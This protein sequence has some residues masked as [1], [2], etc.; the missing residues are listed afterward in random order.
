M[1]FRLEWFLILFF[2]CSNADP[3]GIREV[4]T[5]LE[6]MLLLFIHTK[7]GAR[8]GAY[9]FL[10]GDVKERA[11]MLKAMRDHINTIAFTPNAFLVAITALAC[12]DDTTILSKNLLQ[13]LIPLLSEVATSTTASRIIYSVLEEPSTS[14]FTQ[15]DLKFIQHV[16]KVPTKRSKLKEGEE[17]K[18]N[19][20]GLVAA[21]LKNA[22]LRRSQL[23]DFLMEPLVDDCVANIIKYLNSLSGAGIIKLLIQA[24]KKEVLN[25]LY[26]SIDATSTAP[27]DVKMTDKEDEESEKED[28]E[29]ED[30]EDED[31]DEEG[32]DVKGEDEDGEDEEEEEEEGSKP[33]KRA[34]IAPSEEENDKENQPYFTNKSASILLSNLIKEKD[35]TLVA[36]LCK[37]FAGNFGY[38]AKENSNASFIINTLLHS[39]DKKACAQVSFYNCLIFVHLLM[40]II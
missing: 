21:S 8:I 32:E 1:F 17:V 25:A 37:A 27:S 39:G 26:D 3:V 11:A 20:E 4:I 34:K 5:V 40:V 18:D 30:E 7:D 36:T 9:C 14:H 12:V 10:Y 2:I 23:A 35:T 15:H 29:E 33:A 6:P 31:E 22:S 28:E 24:G 16:A 13:P 19:E 38:W